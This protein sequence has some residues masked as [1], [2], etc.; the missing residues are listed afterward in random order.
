MDRTYQNI[1]VKNILEARAEE[2]AHFED[3]SLKWVNYMNKHGLM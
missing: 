2:D 3:M 1:V